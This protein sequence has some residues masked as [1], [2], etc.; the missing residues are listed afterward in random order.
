MNNKGDNGSPC[1]RPLELEKKPD[2]SPLTK[3]EKRTVE[4]QKGDPFPP[5]DWKAYFLKNSEEEI[6]RDMI[7]SLLNVK[8]TEDT[9]NP[10]SDIKINAFTCNQGNIQKLTTRREGMLR[11]THNFSN[12]SPQS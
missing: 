8:L 7:I 11:W 6:P 10:R 3:I 4:I 1:L 2:A 12:H 5:P 9:R